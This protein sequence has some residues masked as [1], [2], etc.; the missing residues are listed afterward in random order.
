MNWAE[1]QTSEVALEQKRGR[2][3]VDIMMISVLSDFLFFVIITVT[4]IFEVHTK[5]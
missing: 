3:L 2:V 5:K 4:E 1:F